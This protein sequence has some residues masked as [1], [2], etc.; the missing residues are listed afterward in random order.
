M[1]SHSEICH[2]S[3]LHHLPLTLIVHPEHVDHLCRR[4]AI[5]TIHRL[6]N[7]QTRR[8]YIHMVS[9]CPAPTTT[10]VRSAIT[11]RF[12]S[13]ISPRFLKRH[14]NGTSNLLLFSHSFVNH[15][16][17][18]LIIQNPPHRIGQHKKTHVCKVQCPMT[19]LTATDVAGTDVSVVALLPPSDAAAAAA[20]AA[21]AC[22]ACSSSRERRNA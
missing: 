14:F 10:Y 15:S 11:Y 17:L 7:Y 6:R 18:R 12:A 22:R 2:P 13:I 19:Q 9:H 1:M 5:Q 3:Y 4:L 21:A 16:N 20:A 8:W